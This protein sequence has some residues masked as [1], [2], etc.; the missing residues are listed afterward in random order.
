LNNKPYSPFWFNEE[1]DNLAGKGETTFNYNGQ[2]FKNREAGD[3]SICPD[4]F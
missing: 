1:N 4:L 3:W 2:Y